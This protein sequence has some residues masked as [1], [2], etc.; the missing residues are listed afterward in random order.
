[1]L[2][3]DPPP[4]VAA[5]PGEKPA[6]VVVISRDTRSD[7]LASKDTALPLIKADRT[8]D[9][10]LRQAIFLTSTVTVVRPASGD[11]DEI[12][13]WTYQPYL[14]RQLCFT[15]MTGLF[16]CA[17]AE[18]QELTETATGE[19]PLV[20]TPGQA[21]PGPSP[22]ADGA[23]IAVAA[24]LRSRAAALFEDDRRLKLDP[25]LKAAGVSIRRVSV[26][27]RPARR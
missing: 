17:A 12:V 24:T 14:Q 16:S 13:R 9:A 27:A 15:S 10:L 25:M 19:A 2:A 11:G 23:R 6:E 4:A 26:P 21:A 1:M 5:T 22:E 7:V 8:E 18:V 20:S 3:A